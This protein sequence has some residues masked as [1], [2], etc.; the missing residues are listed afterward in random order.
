MSEVNI[1][2]LD[3][4]AQIT[5]GLA[6]A[7]ALHGFNAQVAGNADEALEVARNMPLDLILCDVRMPGIDGLEALSQL[8]QLQSGVR[9]IVMTGYASQDAPLRAI[10]NQ[11]DDYLLKPVPF[12]RLLESVRKSAQ[13]CQV[14][15][16][17]QQ[18][19]DELRRRYLRLLTNLVN[20][21]W[22]QDDYFFEHSRRV[23][24]LAVDIGCELGLDG[25]RLED[26][27][28]AAL[29][30]DIGMA[31]VDRSLLAARRSLNDE[32]RRELEKRPEHL[33]RLLGE[34]PDLK[35]VLPILE[36]LHERYDG[37]GYPRQLRG[38]EIP[39]E[40]RILAVSEAYD[41]LTHA[42]PHR[43]ALEHE[44][45]CQQLRGMP[46]DPALVAL[47]CDLAGEQR[48]LCEP[49]LP[50]DVAK[51][52]W[53]TFLRLGCLFRGQQEYDAASKA[54]F[55]AEK[56]LSGEAQE[57]LV[58][59]WAEWALCEAQ[60]GQTDEALRLLGRLTPGL[61]AA[62][63][64][65]V[66]TVARTYLLVGR[67]ALA[68][69][70]I[71]RGYTTAKEL[72][73]TFLTRGALTLQ[74]AVVEPESEE[75]ARVLRLWLELLP[76]DGLPLPPSQWQ[77][78]LEHLKRGLGMPGLEGCAGALARFSPAPAPE[79]VAPAPEVPRLRMECLGGLRVWVD[80][81]E[82]A[83]AEWSTRKAQEFFV[84]VVLQ[85]KPVAG[86]RLAS[87]LWPEEASKQNLHTTASRARRALAADRNLLRSERNFYQVDRSVDL[88]CDALDFQQAAKNCRPLEGE[89]SPE[90]L[91]AGERALELYQGDL[92]EGFWWD[93]AFELRRSLR[94]AFTQTVLRVA[95][96]YQK[97]GQWSAAQAYYQLGLEREGTQE[98]YNLGVIRCLARQGLRE[99]AVRRY[100]EY[101]R[102][103]HKELALGPS[104]EAV[105]VFMELTAV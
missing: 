39:L 7:L 22:E 24:A 50:R 18:A 63:L 35:R 36:G 28:V 30:H 100:K 42:R 32:E 84:Y 65:V 85:G 74:L 104:S 11:V 23:A 75:W 33:K 51:G 79:V 99:S 4:D 5:R 19:L 55:E 1:L 27:E 68:R 81:R 31:Y 76:A 2:I 92:L 70:L 14:E 90:A 45:A 102:V 101:C 73:D 21:F 29:L 88:Y 6:K 67:K 10:Q 25:E 40:S 43:Q 66:L 49:L 59:V 16:R 62:G 82:I 46:L 60:A 47:A 64:E 83:A 34:L 87:E 93:W 97:V 71:G 8:R 86:E 61:A 57:D 98:A 78:V 44:P 69:Q 26:L 20:A 9:S 37:S 13:I 80:D 94:E 91:A 103:L 41:S 15:K 52:G 77:P 58:T 12:D 105:R 38:H 96:H 3:D 48:G 54:F 53:Q 17:A 56:R 72:G 95:E 89:L